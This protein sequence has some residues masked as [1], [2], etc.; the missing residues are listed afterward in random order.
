[1]GRFQIG[2]IVCHFKRETLRGD[3]LDTNMFKY[4]ILNFAQHSETGE[5]LV[6]YRALYP[7]YNVYARPEEMFNSEVDHKKYP[8]IVQKYRLEV[9]A[10][11][12][13]KL[14][15]V[16]SPYRGNTERNIEYAK[17]LTQLVL[18]NGYAPITPHLYLTQVLDEDDLEQRT[19]GMAAGT[20]ILMQCRYILIGSRYGLSEG[21]M[22]EIKTA[23]EAGLTE[24]AA[25]KQR[26]EIVYGRT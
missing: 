22:A 8:N 14:C 18:D 5:R 7:P 12:E 26:L 24:L 16:C 20:E 23:Y 21:M 6:V 1:M 9:I 15:Y 13:N 10:H 17:E 2:D 4:V 11:S 19:L 3:E 25:V